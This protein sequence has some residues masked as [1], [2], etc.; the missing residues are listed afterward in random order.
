MRATTRLAAGAIAV[1]FAGVVALDAQQSSGPALGLVEAVRLSLTLQP[2]IKLQEERL[3][4]S[5][6]DLQ[7]AEGQFDIKWTNELDRI[8]SELAN[9]AFEQR[10]QFLPR[11]STTNLTTLS[12]S[13]QKQLRS[14]LI[15]SPTLS[16]Q[17][18][19]VSGLPDPGS[20]STAGVTLV[21]PLLRGRGESVVTAGLRSSEREVDG[22][23]TDLKQARSTSALQTA[24]AYW[25]YVAAAGRLEIYLEAERRATRIAD[26]TRTLIN[27]GNRAAAD[28]KQVLANLADQSASRIGG[29]K[30]LFQARQDLG[31]VLG[32]PYEQIGAIPPP[33]D[34]FPPVPGSEVLPPLDTLAAG[35]LSLR[36]DLRSAE[37]RER[38][39]AALIPASRNALRSQFDLV[40]NFTYA[41]LDEGTA[42]YKYLTPFARE[43]TG[44]NFTLNFVWS[45]NINNSGALGRL[46]RS[47]SAVRQAQIR[48]LDLARTIRS[49]VA[50]AYNDLRQSLEQVR[51]S[52]EAS[53]YYESA[54]EDERQKQQL[55][56]STVI[57]LLNTQ[58]RLTRTQLN[59][60]SAEQDYANALVMLRFQ[61]G[62]L[63]QGDGLDAV[64]EQS[65][66]TIP[67]QDQI[68]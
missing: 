25:S 67:R 43:I 30:A 6:G 16:V 47:E 40:A 50:V 12:T 2:S 49:E 8:R 66:T 11:D 59:L 68:R 56:R 32:L 23:V 34:D 52:R 7:S 38:G 18:T 41:G 10:V 61:T 54:V 35:A 60:L 42:I 3:V 15:L 33:A 9:T 51:N 4:T 28:L 55:G 26:E 53:S 24:F 64:D 65:L 46:V 1:V 45:R 36:A 13:L 27:E 44:P 20:R 63:V 19:D 14:G 5:R 31:V 48:N 37:S 57:D 22:N 62:T 39:A 21:Q 58:D 17:R 29:E